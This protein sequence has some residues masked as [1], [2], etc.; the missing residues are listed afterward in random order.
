MKGVCMWGW[1]DW[2]GLHRGRYAR[3]PPHGGGRVLI[4]M[5]ISHRMP[6]GK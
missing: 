2:G 5:V 4:N 1:M 6:D 3:L